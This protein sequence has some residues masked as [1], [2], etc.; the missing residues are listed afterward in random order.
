[1]ARRTDGGSE[2]NPLE[3][4]SRKDRPW[5]TPRVPPTTPQGENSLFPPFTS[6]ESLTLD[7]QLDL[8]EPGKIG[9]GTRR[10]MT[11]S[12]GCIVD[13]SLA[14][15]SMTAFRLP[16]TTPALP[17][18]TRLSGGSGP[19]DRAKGAAAA[20]VVVFDLSTTPPKW[21]IRHGGSMSRRETGFTLRS[22]ECQTDEIRPPEIC[23]GRPRFHTIYTSS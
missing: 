13:T 9:R 21:V 3:R 14:A 8:D 7:L 19:S 12:S 5:P 18:P 22:V 11:S 6:L 4:T 2:A 10:S 23:W 17:V 20:Q 1:M 15:R 16:T